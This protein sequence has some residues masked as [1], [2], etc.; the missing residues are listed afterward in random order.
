MQKAATVLIGCGNRGVSGH[1]RRARRSQSLE[2]V[3]VCDIDA[4]R[5]EAASRQLEVPGERDYRK[6][7]ERDDVQSVI[8]ATTAPY[9]VPI[10]L[11]AVRAGK[12]VLVEKPLAENTAAARELTDAA[13]AAGVVG[14]VGYQSRFSAF[15]AAL[16]RVAG[17]IEPVQMLITRRRRPHDPRHRPRPLGDGRRTGGRVRHHHP[18]DHPG[19]RND[20]IPESA[21]GI[22]GRRSRRRSTCRRHYRWRGSGGAQADAGRA[23]QYAGR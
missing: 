3:A 22:R 21:G 4:A 16:K 13:A 23:R 9:H 18:G 11:D 10:A 6:L 14:M 7:L 5:L 8:V 17:E 20:R 15:G 19:R 1:G 12:H 2:L